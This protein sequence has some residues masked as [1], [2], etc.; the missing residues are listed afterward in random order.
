MRNENASLSFFNMINSKRHVTE[1]SQAMLKTSQALLKKLCP[2]G[3][4]LYCEYRLGKLIVYFSNN[5]ARTCSYGLQITW[6]I[7]PKY[8]FHLKAYFHLFETFYKS[9]PNAF[10]NSIL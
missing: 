3:K 5:I 10:E 6:N 7:Q 1:T 8:F 9:C 2:F 4:R